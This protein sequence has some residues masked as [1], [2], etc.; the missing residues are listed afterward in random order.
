[1]LYDTVVGTEL[2]N[3]IMWGTSPCQFRAFV[4]TAL[5]S[6]HD[7]L[8]LDGGCGSLLFTAV[9]YGGS[10]RRILAFDQSLAMLQRARKRLENLTGGVPEHICL[11]QADLNDLPFRTHKF[12]TVVCLNVLHQFNE[13]AALVSNFRRLLT[14]NGRFY[15]TSLVINER[16]VG[17]WYLRALHLAREFVR[18]RTRLEL[19]TLIETEFR[20]A[21]EL[22][23]VGNMAFVGAKP[24]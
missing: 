18:P 2:Y 8:F 1:V 16:L 7:G 10:K 24:K 14:E 17:D 4:E 19:Q 15:L 5:D 12:N 23:V 20:T 13:A 9:A 22:R 11:L 21:F 3:S 6:N